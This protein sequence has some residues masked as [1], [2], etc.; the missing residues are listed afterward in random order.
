MPPLNVQRGDWSARIGKKV[1]RG[2]PE[3][4]TGPALRHKTGGWPRWQFMS[5]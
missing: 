2:L 3:D 5:T 1:E 4:P